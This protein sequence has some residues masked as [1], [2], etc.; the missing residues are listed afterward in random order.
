MATPDNNC[1]LEHRPVS[2]RPAHGDTDFQCPLRPNFFIKIVPDKT[3][4]T[5][6]VENSRAL[7]FL[8]E[9]PGQK[10][11]F[12]FLEL[13]VLEGGRDRL[14]LSLALYSRFLNVQDSG[15]GMTKNELIN[16][17]GTRL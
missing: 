16:N 12:F 3:N 11:C 15:I 2:M 7:C 9:V 8:I 4:S 5:L 13:S 1:F 6:T 14:W 10:S 17:L